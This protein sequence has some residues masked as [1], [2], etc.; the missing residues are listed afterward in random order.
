MPATPPEQLPPHKGPG[1]PNRKQLLLAACQCEA[2]QL[3]LHQSCNVQEGSQLVPPDRC[4]VKPAV[5]PPRSPH[6]RPVLA[7]NSRCCSAITLCS[8]L[9]STNNTMSAPTPAGTATMQTT[10]SNTATP[11][12]A[13]GPPARHT[14][15]VAFSICKQQHHSAPTYCN[16]ISPY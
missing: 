6:D 11:A 7:T 8:A 16:K 5:P 3:Q 15:Q 4:L 10:C 9:P 13:Q 12:A 2:R 1:C 14:T